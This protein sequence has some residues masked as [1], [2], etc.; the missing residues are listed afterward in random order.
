MGHAV[1]AREHRG[2]RLRVRKHRVKPG[3]SALAEHD[4]AVPVPLDPGGYHEVVS[5]AAADH[6]PAEY[7]Q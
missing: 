6:H 7:V 3:R 5:T 2:S 1:P 4:T